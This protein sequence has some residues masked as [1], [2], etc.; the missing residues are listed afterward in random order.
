[1]EQ[2]H[3]LI[4]HLLFMNPKKKGTKI[5]T[6]QGQGISHFIMNQESW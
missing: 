1:M 2:R 4:L 3:D 5:N 6:I